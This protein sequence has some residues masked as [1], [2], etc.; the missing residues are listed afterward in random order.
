MALKL[1]A[2]DA[3][4]LKSFANLEY[5]AYTRSDEIAYFEQH[6][7]IVSLDLKRRYQFNYCKMEV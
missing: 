5:V 7:E 3:K 6:T 2:I 4:L 1:N